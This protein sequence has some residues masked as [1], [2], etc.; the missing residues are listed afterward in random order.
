[1]LGLLKLVAQLTAAYLLG[2]AAIPAIIVL[3]VIWANLSG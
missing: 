2:L 3:V 1:M